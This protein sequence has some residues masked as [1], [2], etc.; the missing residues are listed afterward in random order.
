MSPSGPLH[1]HTDRVEIENGG[2]GKVVLLAIP[3]IEESIQKGETYFILDLATNVKHSVYPIK[4][5]TCHRDEMVIGSRS[6]ED[7]TTV[8]NRVPIRPY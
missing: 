7:W 8:M 5:K 2:E 3:D 4:C 1:E 6:E